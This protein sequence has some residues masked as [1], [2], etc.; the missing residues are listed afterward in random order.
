MRVTEC[1]CALGKDCETVYMKRERAGERGEV[2][3]GNSKGGCVCGAALE[4]SHSDSTSGGP[5][6]SWREARAKQETDRK[7]IGPEP[8][9]INHH[10]GERPSHTHAYTRTNTHTAGNEMWQLE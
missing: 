5:G 7:Q 2:V 1:V 3:E 6:E 10:G 4:G 8:A 9:A